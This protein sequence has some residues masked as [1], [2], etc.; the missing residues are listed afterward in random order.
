M[1]MDLHAKEVFLVLVLTAKRVE[2]ETK[3]D[4]HPPGASNAAW[5]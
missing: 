4:G 1:M 2:K 5:V 3:K